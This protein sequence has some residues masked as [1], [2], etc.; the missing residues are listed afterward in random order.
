MA[1]A[2]M[3]AGAAWAAVS[4]AGA[5]EAAAVALAAAAPLGGGNDGP[6]THWPAPA[7]AGLAGTAGLSAGGARPHRSR[8]RRLGAHAR[9][10]DPLCGGGSARSAAAATRHERAGAGSGCVL[11]A[12]GL[13]YRAQQ[14]RADLS[15]ARR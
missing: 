1:A 7:A 5:S 15:A 3:A 9:R 4:A 12:A 14:R 8:H 2:S 6:E 11:H 10:A 13:G